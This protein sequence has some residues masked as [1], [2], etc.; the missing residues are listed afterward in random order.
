MMLLFSAN[1][2]YIITKK[3]AK[4]SSSKTKG[5]LITPLSFYISKPA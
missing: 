4:K 5:E 3:L 2:V 1:N